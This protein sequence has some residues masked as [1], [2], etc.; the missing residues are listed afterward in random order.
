MRNLFSSHAQHL[1]VLNHVYTAVLLQHVSFNPSL[2]KAL[3][4]QNH[5]YAAVT[6]TYL[7]CNC[8]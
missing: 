5:A 2:C 7:A 3:Q 1:I 6:S 4:F 8:N